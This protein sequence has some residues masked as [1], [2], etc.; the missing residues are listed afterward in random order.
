[1]RARSL[2]SSFRPFKVPA[3]GGGGEEN[4]IQVAASRG[5]ETPAPGGEELSEGFEDF[6]RAVEKLFHTN[7][8][9]KNESRRFIN[10]WFN[11]VLQ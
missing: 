9:G 5:V 11:L 2:F 8:S 10:S 7:F 1:M 3:E 6:F 4:T